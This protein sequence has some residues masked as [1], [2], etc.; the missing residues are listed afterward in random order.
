MTLELI[1]TG[2]S[3][4]KKLIFEAPRYSRFIP[5]IIVIFVTIALGIFVVRVFSGR[6][7]AVKEEVITKK[8]VKPSANEVR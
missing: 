7:P 5:I 2:A 3:D 8:E 1:E 4:S 6:A